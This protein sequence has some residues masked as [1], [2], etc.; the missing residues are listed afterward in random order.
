MVSIN[1]TQA[2]QA[3][4]S[5][6]GGALTYIASKALLNGIYNQIPANKNKKAPLVQ[7]STVRKII[8]FISGL[9]GIGGALY[10]AN[11]IGLI[12]VKQLTEKV[13]N[14]RNAEKFDQAAF[15]QEIYGEK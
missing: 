2:Q 4:V 6:V 14:F 10:T 8:T 3:A 9:V 12:S 5:I 1:S 13:T 11:M 7:E 15:L